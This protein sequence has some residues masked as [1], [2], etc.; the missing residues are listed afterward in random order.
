MQSGTTGINTLRIYSP[1]KQALDHDP[2]GE[3]IR[4]WVPEWGTPAYP[5]PIVD[6]QAAARA[7]KE[8]MY[9][10]RGLPEAR[11]EADQIQERH[12]SRLSGLPPS[13]SRASRR[14]PPTPN[15]QRDLFE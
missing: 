8:R 9:G 4:R 6:E 11:N 5:A 7:A 12:G 14:A 10:L 2:Q 1:S 13:G 3:F 15:L